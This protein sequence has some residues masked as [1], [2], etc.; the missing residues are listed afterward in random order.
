VVLT[1]L[2][3]VGN[4]LCGENHKFTY[5]DGRRRAR[6]HVASKQA[7]LLQLAPKFDDDSGELKAIK[8]RLEQ[9]QARQYDLLPMEEEEEE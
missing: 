8:K 6:A 3:L 7:P 4:S 9:L 5:G 2:I 1:S